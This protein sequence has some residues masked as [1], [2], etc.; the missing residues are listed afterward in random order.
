MSAMQKRF[1]AMMDRQMDLEAMLDAA[2][3]ENGQLTQQIIDLEAE[4]DEL[5]RPAK[6]SVLDIGDD[7]NEKT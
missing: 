7:S 6:V 5:T 2:K 3:A 4:I 1:N